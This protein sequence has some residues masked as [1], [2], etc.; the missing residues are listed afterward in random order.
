MPHRPGNARATERSLQIRQETRCAA[1]LLSIV[2]KARRVSTRTMG[3]PEARGH[4]W[5][6]GEHAY[7]RLGR[8]RVARRRTVGDLTPQVRHSFFI[9]EANILIFRIDAQN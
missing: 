6:P 7:V 3:R 5:G 8:T 2:A 4:C 1:Q 9:A